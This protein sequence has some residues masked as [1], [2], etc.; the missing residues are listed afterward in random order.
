MQVADNWDTDPDY[1]IPGT[2]DTH[3][4]DSV[5]LNFVQLKAEVRNQKLQLNK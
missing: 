4:H 2:N 3:F 1:C 5:H